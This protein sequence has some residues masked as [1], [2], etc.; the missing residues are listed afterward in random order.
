MK[1]VL[2]LCNLAFS[3]QAIKGASWLQP[4][5]EK[6]QQSNKILILNISVGNVSKIT[7]TEYKGIKQWILPQSK[8]KQ[9]GQTATYKRCKEVQNI[10]ESEKPDLV[11]IWGTEIFW[12]SIYAKGFIKTKTLID[13]QGLLYAYTDFYLGGLTIN[14]ILN[15]IHI[16]EI[17]MPWRN[18]FTKQQI[19]FKRGQVELRYIKKFEHISIQSQW[20]R[21][22]LQQVNPI[23]HYYPT[24]ILLR[25]N[26]YTA[27]PWSYKN[28]TSPIIFSSCAAAVSYKGIHVLLK[29]LALL[30]KEYPEIQLHLAGKIMVGDK[31]QDGYSIFLK[32]LIKK[33]NLQSNIVLLGSIDE[34]NIIKELQSCSVCVIPSFIETYCL[35]FAEAMIIGVPTVTSYTGAMPELA[36]HEKETLFYNSLDYRNAAS[37][38]SRLIKDQALAEQIS[39]NARKRR[40]QEN[41]PQLVL[42]TQLN[43][44]KSILYEI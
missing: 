44:Y 15:T 1:K 13:I 11:H 36:T 43:I 41:A 24:R 22:L 17:L 18:L 2:W 34:S 39:Q 35:A 42:N 33:L 6:L 29:S 32:K 8:Q 26:F 40:L 14:E 7:Y 27:Q 10:I 23:A 37:H 16:K 3:D 12:A 4:L 31:L 19:F 9:Y 20:V 25:D 38:I 5:A 30:K 21:N 28:T